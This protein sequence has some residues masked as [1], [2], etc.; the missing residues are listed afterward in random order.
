M[1]HW[2]V[3]GCLFIGV[4]AYSEDIW[5]ITKLH[6]TSDSLATRVVN[7]NVVDYQAI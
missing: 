6:N 7:P 2:F 5:S 4:M 3:C 1:Y